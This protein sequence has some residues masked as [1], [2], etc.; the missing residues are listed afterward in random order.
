MLT[1][2]SLIAVLTA[3]TVLTA[4]VAYAADQSASPQAS[5]QE[6]PAERDF[7]KLSASGASAYMEV[8]AAR[9]AIFDGRVNEAKT[10]I[11]KA[12]T[13][14]GQAKG[15]ETAFMKAEADMKGP[16]TGNADKTDA[17]TASKDSAGKPNA[18]DQASA[19]NMKTPKEWL[20]VDGDMSVSEDLTASP[21]KQAA[22]ADANKSLAKGDKKGALEKLK[23]ADIDIDYSIAVVPL[24]QTITDVHQ[25]ATLVNGGKYY[26]ASQKLRDVQ[27]S[28]RFDVLDINGMPKQAA[29]SSAD[30]GKPATH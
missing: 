6:K 9:V 15:D 8:N 21:A 23:V 30:A 18:G 17:T 5:S 19:A 25:A 10:L 3:T 20:P 12:D 13:D 14:L 26:E 29:A 28:T 1:I 24:Q 22:V 4:G 7:G 2:K 16:Q 11:N 27:D